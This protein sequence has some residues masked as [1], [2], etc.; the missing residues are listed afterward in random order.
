M[1]FGMHADKISQYRII[2]NADATRTTQ[3]TEGTNADIIAR[4]KTYA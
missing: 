4:R 1:V 2:A 3:E